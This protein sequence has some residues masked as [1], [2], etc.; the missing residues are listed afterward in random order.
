LTT[1]TPSQTTLRLRA[2]WLVIVRA[3]WLIVATLTLVM[4][5]VG[6]PF[7]FDTLRTVCAQVE[8]SPTQPTPDDALVLRQLGLSLNF[9]GAYLTTLEIV[10]TLVSVL[11]G[12]VIFWR[13]SDDWMGLFVSLMLVTPPISPIID[14]LVA[15]QPAWHWPALLVQNL[16][17][18]SFGIFFYLFPDGRF[19]PRWTR[20]L[21]LTWL[22]HELLLT[23]WSEITRTPVRSPIAPFLFLAFLIIGLVTQIYR[24]A[25]VA[26]PVQRQQTK[27]VVFGMTVAVLGLTGAILLPIIFPLVLQPGLPQV[28]SN[29]VT[30]LA[31]LGIPLSLI[32]LTIG[33]AILRYRL[34]DI[35]FLINRSLVYGGL[36]ALLLAL[37]GLSL[38]VISRL[39]QD[40]A[41]GPLVAVAVAAAALST[42][43]ACC[44]TRSR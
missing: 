2:H 41:G 39:F 4:Y 34:W 6:L 36:T 26:G 17:F 1:N 42:L 11:V 33:I 25:R 22:T 32:P 24:Y 5:G 12:V 37:C 9:Y 14:A 10:I 44:T 23:L 20:W 28:L 27:V 13:R 29:L 7:R 19:V 30:A 16:G 15:V 40:F 18:L 35:D 3:A 8:C 38:L 21:A 43:P 31:L